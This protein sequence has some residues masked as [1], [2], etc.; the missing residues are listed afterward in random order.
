M[1]NETLSV[2]F[3]H[4]AKFPIFF[5]FHAKDV[6]IMNEIQNLNCVALKPGSSAE[7]NRKKNVKMWSRPN[8]DP[9]PEENVEDPK[10][11]KKN[12]HKIV[13]LFS[14]VKCANLKVFIF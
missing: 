14:G 3:K 12:V 13:N 7:P 1:L 6:S 8:V 5:R 2:I 11:N 4:H 9:C 10:L